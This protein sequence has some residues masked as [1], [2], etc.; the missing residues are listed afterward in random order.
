MNTF[1][2]FDIVIASEPSSIA[3]S[4][5]TRMDTSKSNRGPHLE[6]TMFKD[7]AKWCQVF[8]RWA[9]GNF[10]IL[11]LTSSKGTVY[12]GNGPFVDDLHIIKCWIPQPYVSL[13]QGTSSISDE[14]TSLVASQL[15]SVFFFGNVIFSKRSYN[16]HPIFGCLYH[17][18]LAALWI[19]YWVRS[20]QN[21]SISHIAA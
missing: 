2:F 10:L 5:I 4:Q 18:F 9:P 17:P 11:P 1:P 15:G 6:G 12:Y 19:V 14:F 20:F 8:P 13:P 16:E 21:D 3:S 7:T